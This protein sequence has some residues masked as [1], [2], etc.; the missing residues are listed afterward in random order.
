MVEP[1]PT[2]LSDDAKKSY[3]P[4]CTLL[5]STSAR[6]FAAISDSLVLSKYPFAQ[7]IVGIATVFEIRCYLLLRMYYLMQVGKKQDADDL[8][9]FCASC[10]AADAAEDFH[11]QD[12][13]CVVQ[14]RLKVLGESFASCKTYRDGVRRELKALS[15]IILDVGSAQKIEMYERDPSI[16]VIRDFLVESLVVEYLNAAQASF[17]KEFD[18]AMGSVMIR[19]ETRVMDMAFEDVVGGLQI[20]LRRYQD[21]SGSGSSRGEDIA[22]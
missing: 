10:I 8:L 17:V 6:I 21:E 3:L 16:L 22:P 19:P 15:C 2:P 18:H 9:S 20:G 11:Q 13:L 1:E 5:Y 4:L 14:N 7:G 12:T